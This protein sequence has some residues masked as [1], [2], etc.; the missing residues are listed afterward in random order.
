MYDKRQFSRLTRNIDGKS[1]EKDL[2]LLA[3]KL[4]PKT[5]ILKH[6][7]FR[8]SGH[9][10]L[11]EFVLRR[12]YEDLAQEFTQLFANNTRLHSR[13]LANTWYSVHSS[14]PTSRPHS[15]WEKIA[16]GDPDAY[17]EIGYYDFGG[18]LLFNSAPPTKQPPIKLF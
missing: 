16:N 7:R 4:L 17:T 15:Y 11:A 9:L 13:S 18:K 6:L 8:K 12:E 14:P 5:P 10:V 2:A 1:T 3:D